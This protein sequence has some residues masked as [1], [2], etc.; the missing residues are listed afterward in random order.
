MGAL[1]LAACGGDDGSPVDADSSPEDVLDAAL[2]GGGEPIESGV[3]DLQFDLEADTAELGSISAEVSGPFS[4]NGEGELPDLDLDVSADADVGGPTVGFAGGIVL[5]QDGLWVQYQDQA[6]E[7]DE[8]TFSRVVDS[9]AKSSELQDDESEGGSL[10]QF[11]V[12]PQ[13]WLTDVTNEGTEDVDGT[14]TV[15]VSGTGD[16]SK[17]VKD[18][19]SV[20]SQS[21]QEQLGGSQLSQL[22][23]SISNAQVDVYAATDDG[24]LRRID[25]AVDVANGGDNGA[26][27]VTLSIGIADPNSDQSV[28]AP[29]DAL[30]LSD[31]LGQFPGATDSLGG[32]APPSGDTGG[33][34][35]GGDANAYYQC[36]QEAP[37]PEAVSDCARFLQ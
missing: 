10:S 36:V 30:P 27:T 18:L 1:L 25:I 5:T 9:Y 21:G 7:L 19:D 37:S 24:S 4:S 23:D 29:E 8:A 12:D 17:I 11:G 2:G 15:H 35:G 22:E 32:L 3:L 6:Y 13:D 26:S 34:G 16:I 20:A 31:L 33:S 14:E 28:D